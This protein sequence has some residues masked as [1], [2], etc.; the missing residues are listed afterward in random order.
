MMEKLISNS[1]S[2]NQNILKIYSFVKNNIASKTW[3]LK[4]NLE[5]HEIFIKLSE[6]D[7]NSLINDFSNWSELEQNIVSDCVAYGIDGKF[8]VKYENER[9]LLAQKLYSKMQNGFSHPE[10]KKWKKNFRVHSK[11]KSQNSRVLGVYDYLLKNEYEDSDYWSLGGGSQEIQNKLNSFSDKDWEDLK[12]DVINW[13]EDDIDVLIE[14]VAYGFDKMFIPYL[15]NEMVSRAGKFLLDLFILNIGDRNE[16]VYYSF[17][18]AQSD[19][20]NLKD[21]ETLKEWLKTNGYESEIWMKSEINPL[22]SIEE[23]IKKASR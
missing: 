2:S 10:I 17:F 1:K 12:Q 8:E 5:L 11:T 3:E 14:S 6:N 18:I 7:W 16:I 15:K 9:R 20:N 22:K 19:L 4:E 13:N 21:L 23:A